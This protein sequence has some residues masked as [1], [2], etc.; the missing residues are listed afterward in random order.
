[1]RTRRRHHAA[2]GPRAAVSGARSQGTP[3]R[4]PVRPGGRLGARQVCGGERVPGQPA[5][6]A[7][8]WPVALACAELSR[9]GP[10]RDADGGAAWAAEAPAG[11]AVARTSPV[12]RPPRP[13]GLGWRG[14]PR[15]PASV[16]GRRSRRVGPRREGMPEPTHPS[17]F[18]AWRPRSCLDTCPPAPQMVTAEEDL[19]RAQCPGAGGQSPGRRSSG[20]S[21]RPALP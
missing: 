2:S 13:S 12:T 17:A 19:R 15:T 5:G 9:S 21:R 16:A 11:P 10:G 20:P 6:V 1:M 3:G 4:A 18:L 8:T 7:V 14:G